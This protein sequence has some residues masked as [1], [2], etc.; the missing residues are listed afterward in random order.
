VG[1]FTYYIRVEANWEGRERPIFAKL[2]IEMTCRQCKMGKGLVSC[3]GQ[4][5]NLARSKREFKKGDEKGF[6]FHRSHR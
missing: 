4:H 2:T 6:G 5:P 3:E 1:K